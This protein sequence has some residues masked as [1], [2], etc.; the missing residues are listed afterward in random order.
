MWFTKVR[1]KTFRFAVTWCSLLLVLLISVPSTALASAKIILILD[2]MGYRLSDR[3][4]LSL[5]QE[6]TF[7]ILPH[8]PLSLELSEY[9]HVQGRDV[10]L[11]MPMEA[12]NGKAL[13]PNGLTE[14]MVAASISETFNN[15]LASVP[16]AIGVNNHMGSKLTKARLPMQMLMNAIKEKDL[17]FIDSRTTAD[18]IAEST[19]RQQGI[20]AARRNVFI[21]HDHS[22]VAMH[23]QFQRLIDIAKRDGV[24]VG[25]AHPHPGTLRFLETALTT[26]DAENVELSSV[27][28]YFHP[29][30]VD[31]TPQIAI[32]K[33]SIAPE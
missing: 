26:L 11:H 29:A 21:D 32:E 2:D 6:V 5:P 18:S 23:E 7:S 1:L 12:E 19:A 20:L 22:L 4:A 14:G 13:G 3:K 28:G 31:P 24:A 25:I 33:R 8:T 30:H 10:M 16:Y 9:A 17:F 27:S 15:A